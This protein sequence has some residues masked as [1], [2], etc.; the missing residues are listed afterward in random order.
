MQMKRDRE[1]IGM[2]SLDAFS[3]LDQDHDARL[4]TWRF[5]RGTVVSL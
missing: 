1:A 5:A 4:E 2:L 3:I